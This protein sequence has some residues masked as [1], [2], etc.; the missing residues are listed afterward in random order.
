METIDYNDLNSTI[1][2]THL[3]IDY[4][5]FKQILMKRTSDL[6][7]SFF[8]TPEKDKICFD[9]ISESKRKIKI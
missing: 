6:E 9:K 8:E 3:N 7:E 5:D 1:K 4:P 2:T